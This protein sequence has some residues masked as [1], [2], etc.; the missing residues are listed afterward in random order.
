MVTAKLLTSKGLLCMLA[1][2]TKVHLQSV[3]LFILQSK[4]WG[5]QSGEPSRSGASQSGEPSRSG[6]SQSGE[7]FKVEW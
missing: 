7:P 3:L 2:M 4:K 6:A 5:L 1:A